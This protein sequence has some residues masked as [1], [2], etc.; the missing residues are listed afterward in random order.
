MTHE[1]MIEK[2]KH[3]IEISPPGVRSYTDYTFDEC[4]AIARDYQAGPLGRRPTGSRTRLRTC[5]AGWRVA[6]ST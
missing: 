4:A 3:G 2:L 1:E 6:V 5:S